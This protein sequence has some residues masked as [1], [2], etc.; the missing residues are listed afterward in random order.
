MKQTAKLKTLVLSMAV[1]GSSIAA[2]APATTQA[3][4]SGNIG[5]VNQYIF[6]G[7]EQSGS[8]T[9]QAGLDYEHESGGYVGVWGSEVG[10]N[11][12]LEYDLYGGWSGE[13]SG[14]SVG[15]GATLYNYT[16]DLSKDDNAFDTAYQEVNLSVGY[17]SLP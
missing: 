13:F 4:V 9:A 7:I 16:K 10:D 5:L 1:A 6:R 14:V 12:G 3:G 2:L 17:I 15:L 11:Q 8:A